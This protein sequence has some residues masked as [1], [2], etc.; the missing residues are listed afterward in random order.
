MILMIFKKIY[1]KEAIEFIKKT[2]SGLV[3]RL[4]NLNVDV[5][6]LSK[7]HF[8]FHNLASV[9]IIGLLAF[10]GTFFSI[11]F[12]ACSVNAPVLDTPVIKG[13]DNEMI[14]VNYGNTKVIANLAKDKSGN[15]TR[16]QFRLIVEKR[17]EAAISKDNSYVIHGESAYAGSL[18][19]EARTYIG[20]AY[21]Y[22]A[23]GPNVFGCS[24]FVSYVFSRSGINIPRIF[25]GQA[26]A[27]DVATFRPIG[28]DHA[29]IYSGEGT[30]IHALNLMQGLKKLECMVL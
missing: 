20:K 18:L 3:S 19:A 17:K 26:S 15:E 7:I 10:F 5:A 24:V 13:Y 2:K 29:M 25:G 12:N 14:N 4:S 30:L 27:S 16:Q 22:G 8:N 11:E 28:N 6:Y 23:S 21:V 1:I 9:T